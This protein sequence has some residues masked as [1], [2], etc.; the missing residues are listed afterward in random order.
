MLYTYFGTSIGEVRQKALDHV[1]KSAEAGATITTI[2]TDTYVPG[3]LSDCTQAASLFL[4]KQIFLIDTPSEKQD[5][6]TDVLDN[7]ELLKESEHEFVIIEDTLN[8]A[9][10]KKFGSCGEMCELQ[11]EKKETFNTFSLTDA[12]LLKD[13]KTLWLKLTEAVQAGVSLEEIVGV[14]FWQIKILRLVEKSKSADE[15]GQKPF[16][17]QKA[18]RALAKFK[19][20][21]LSE[22]SRGLLKLYHDGHMGKADMRNALE[23]WVLGL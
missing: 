11:G 10:K 21:E 13:K 20:G 23:Q 5:V 18:Q 22:L 19:P 7:L 8:A 2:T 15:A 6:F 1:R 16:V 9:A 12:L 17:Y 14:L 4:E 3:M